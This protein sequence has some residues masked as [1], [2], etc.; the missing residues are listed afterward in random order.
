V[1]QNY[2]V[3]GEDPPRYGNAHPNIVPYEVFPTADGYVA[4][5][6]GN[7]AQYERF[8]EVANC[9]EFWQ[10]S[11]YK[12]NASRVEHRDELIP[13]LQN[14]FRKRSSS[15]W[16]DLLHQ[17]NIPAGSINSVQQALT[18]PQVLSRQM[19]QTITH[20]TAGEIKLLGPVAKFSNTPAKIQ[21]HPPLLGE[22]T[23]QVLED[24]LGRSA[25][26]I[27]RL[28]GDSVI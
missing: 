18:D 10:E 5:G 8:C 16:L 9:L 1:A 13:L 28:E 17:E 27:Q 19:V 3:S 15:E 4:V 21:S 11:K 14:V 6:I 12:T 26:E 7:D 2:L 25:E 24:L 22:H 20:P 23:R